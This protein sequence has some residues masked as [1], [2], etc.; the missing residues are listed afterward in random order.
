MAAQG[1]ALRTRGVPNSGFR[2]FVRIRIHYSNHCSAPK[3]I[4]G[5]SLLRTD[6]IKVKVDQQEGGAMCRMCWDREETAGHIS[7]K[8]YKFYWS[9]ARRRRR[10]LF[11]TNN[12]NIKQEK[13]NINVS[14][15]QAARKAKSHLCWP[16]TLLTQQKKRRKHTRITSRQN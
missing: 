7:S 4:S 12:N 8:C 2:L 13:D 1:H 10:N 3:R 14:S 11:A 16:P 9:L 6:A 5:T 15:Q